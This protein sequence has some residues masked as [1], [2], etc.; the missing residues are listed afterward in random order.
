[1]LRFFVSEGQDLAFVSLR[2]GNQSEGCLLHAACFIARTSCSRQ[3]M[4]V[5]RID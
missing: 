5:K 4:G 1:M 2:R 3:Q